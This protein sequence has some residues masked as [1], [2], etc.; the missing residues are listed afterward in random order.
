[1]DWGLTKTPTVRVEH[2][3]RIDA[4]IHERSTSSESSLSRKLKDLKLM[5]DDAAITAAEYEQMKKRL[6]QKWESSKE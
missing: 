2:D 4:T 5:K 6:I 3:Q 1:L